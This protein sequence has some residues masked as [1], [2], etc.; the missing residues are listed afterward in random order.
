MSTKF[1]CDERDQQRRPT[2]VTR[3]SS[4]TSDAASS[5]APNDNKTTLS[6]T[7]SVS[8]HSLGIAPFEIESALSNMSA[9]P[10]LVSQQ[11]DGAHGGEPEDDED[12]RKHE[13]QPS[14]WVVYYFQIIKA[15]AILII[16]PT[17]AQY[18]EALNA[19]ASLSGLLVGLFPAAGVL[20]AYPTYWAITRWNFKYVCCICAIGGAMGN[21]IYALAYLSGS[22]GML[23]ASRVVSGLFQFGQGPYDYIGRAIS[24][25]RRTTVMLYM[26][27][28][29]LSG[30]IL[31]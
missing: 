11:H 23:L 9:D 30:T 5:T 20:S 31:F 4:L 28:A 15:A 1:S 26:S 6:A 24:M 22:P 19:P 10:A 14:L 27:V 29:I 17:S 13:H 18:V 16:V 8:G 7:K 12:D 21:V 2:N 25:K 3:L